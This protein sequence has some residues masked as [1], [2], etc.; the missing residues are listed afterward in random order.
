MDKQTALQHASRGAYGDQTSLIAALRAAILGDGFATYAGNPTGIVT[1]ANAGEWLYDSTNQ[2]FYRAT[3]TANTSWI[4]E[5]LNPANTVEFFDDFLG[6][7]IDSRWAVTKGSDGA[8]V[9]FAHLT[10]VNGMIRATMGA[11]AGVSMAANGVQL[12]SALQYKAN[13][14]GLS[15]EAR[16]KISAI[17][18]VALFVGFTDQIA[19]L[20]MPIYS[21]ASADT[22]TTDATDAVGFMFDTSMTTDNWW[23]TGVANNT[24]ATAQNSGLAPVADTFETLRVDVT[25]AGVATFR[26]NGVVLGSAMTGAVTPTVALT[27]VVAGFSRVAGSR[28]VE[29]D[30][31]RTRNTRV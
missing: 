19:A 27:P 5:A 10:G 15:F 7:V 22:L 16:V 20:E 21:A 13:S 18:T 31:I 23:L 4:V 12:H 6:D 3:T 2:I 17:T 14:G 28:T 11:G 8:C 24:D 1:P 25:A 30:F 29:L 26:R 9:D